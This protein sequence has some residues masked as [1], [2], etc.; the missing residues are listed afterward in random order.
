[1]R[2]QEI[3]EKLVDDQKKLTD[4]GLAKVALKL[5]LMTL[6]FC[7][8]IGSLVL[9][10]YGVGFTVVVI[11]MCMLFYNWS[12][13]SMSVDDDSFNIFMKVLKLWWSPYILFILM[14][15]V[16]TMFRF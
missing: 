2:Y 1:M 12:L 6:G 16:L 15:V 14:S 13:D 5:G 3:K 4:K 8:C 11:L 7:L 9:R 10:T